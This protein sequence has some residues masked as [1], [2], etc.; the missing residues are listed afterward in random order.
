M[1]LKNI[2]ISDYKNL[3]DFSLI[4]EGDSFMDIYVGKN[5]SGRSNLLEAILMTRLNSTTRDFA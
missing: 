1:R 4:F 3:N 2:Y 5:D